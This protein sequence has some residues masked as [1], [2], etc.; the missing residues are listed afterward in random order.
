MEIIGGIFWLI[1]TVGLF[2]IKRASNQA[3]QQKHQQPRVEQSVELSEVDWEKA[4]A[5][6]LR[7][8]QGAQQSA[9]LQQDAVTKRKSIKEF[10]EGV[11]HAQNSVASQPSYQSKKN[12]YDLEL[13]DED[14][15][16]ET[17][18]F[19]EQ[20][21]DAYFASIDGDIDWENYETDLFEDSDWQHD[22]EIIKVVERRPAMAHGESGGQHTLLNAS[23]IKEAIVL[24]EILGKPKSRRK[25]I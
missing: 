20:D 11:Q 10:V 5:A 22:E 9:R 6:K 21:D 24:S 2:F 19:Y 3:K 14:M 17:D 4:K 16:F 12:E 1:W 18:S 8:N 13:Y 7:R 23:N 25:T 15:S